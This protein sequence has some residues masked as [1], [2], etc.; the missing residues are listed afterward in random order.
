MIRQLPE[1]K[2]QDFHDVTEIIQGSLRWNT[3]NNARKLLFGKSRTL[4]GV[5][6]EKSN[7]THPILYGMIQLFANNHVPFSYDYVY[8]A[9]NW[10]ANYLD[11]IPTLESVYVV[12]WGEYTGGK[13]V[14]VHG[15]NNIQL[16]DIN[17]KPIIGQEL[18]QMF[19][20]NDV[21][22]HQY[23][24]IFCKSQNAIDFLW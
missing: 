12:S 3:S 19:I 5:K 6:I 21:K 18:E 4:F 16:Y 11:Y 7:T 2:I 22:G 14:I 20:N 15:K 13:L 23:T 24:L 10:N 8:L 1:L 9:H 17:M